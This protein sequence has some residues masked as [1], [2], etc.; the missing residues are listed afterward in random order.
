MNTAN[1]LHFCFIE[2]TDKQHFAKNVA[3]DALIAQRF[4]PVL[5]EEF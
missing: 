4:G 1:I 3:L 2:L 5:D